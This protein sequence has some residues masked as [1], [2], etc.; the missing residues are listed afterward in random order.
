[1]KR[2]ATAI[3]LALA[4]LLFGTGLGKERSVDSVTCKRMVL[5]GG[6]IYVENRGDTPVRLP[7]ESWG[8]VGEVRN[9]VFANERPSLPYYSNAVELIGSSLYG[10]A[11]APETLYL[12]LASGGITSYLRFDQAKSDASIYRPVVRLDGRYYAEAGYVDSLPPEEEGWKVSGVITNS[13]DPG[14]APKKDYA[15][16]WQDL[17]G[18]KVVRREDSPDTLYLQFPL[19]G[20]DY[21]MRCTYV[22]VDEEGAAPQLVVGGKLYTEV[23]EVEALPEEGFVQA[24]NAVK[25]GSANRAPKKELGTNYAAFVGSP[26]YRDPENDSA[27]YIQY[28]R[29]V[30]NRILEFRLADAGGEKK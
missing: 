12:Q 27:V 19:G 3:F 13:G 30:S 28:Y 16:N 22:P 6:S 29:G 2:A 9:A 20:Q 11:G 17:V 26:V 5:Y 25:D 10:S 14:K 4:L 8:E 1:M 15:A 18:A 24:G 7:D 23:G 21:V